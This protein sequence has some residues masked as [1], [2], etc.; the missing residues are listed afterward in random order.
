[1]YVQILLVSNGVSSNTKESNHY[2]ITVI[3]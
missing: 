1:M 3:A 2:C